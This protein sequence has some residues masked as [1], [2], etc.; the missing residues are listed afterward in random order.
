MS[1][2]VFLSEK[3]YIIFY[4]V[5]IPSNPVKVLNY[6]VKH[7]YLNLADQAA[8]SSLGCKG[9]QMAKSLS[10]EAL[11]A[12]VRF[13]FLLGS[14]MRLIVM[15]TQFLYNE[16]WQD[17]LTFAL[18]RCPPHDNLELQLRHPTKNSV[19]SQISGHSPIVNNLPSKSVTI[20]C[21]LGV[22]ALKD[23]DCLPI[24]LKLRAEITAEIKKIPKFSTFIRRKVV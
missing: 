24:D 18:V 6:A 7:G 22:K 10:S 4:R 12:W 23:L 2:A 8:F 21:R 15:G 9:D 1:I 3:Q 13:S 11:K 19:A 20:L 16:R 14:E 17:V 5:S